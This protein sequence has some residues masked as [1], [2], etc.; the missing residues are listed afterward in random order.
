VNDKLEEA[1]SQFFTLLEALYFQEIGVMKR[2]I[3]ERNQPS[4]AATDA[5]VSEKAEP[6]A[7]Q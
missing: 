3:A 5:A 2:K 7:A 4:A 6:T 1:T